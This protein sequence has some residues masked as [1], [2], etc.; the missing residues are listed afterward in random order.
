MEYIVVGPGTMPLKEIRA[1]VADIMESDPAAVFGAVVSGPI[2]TENT[3]KTVES[4]FKSSGFLTPSEAGNSLALYL[5]E[6]N[7]DESLDNMLPELASLCAV[8]EW[9]AEGMFAGADEWPIKLLVLTPQ[10]GTP[11]P[12]ELTDLIRKAIKSGIPAMA[13]N[14][15]MYELTESGSESEELQELSRDELKAMALKAGVTAEDWRSKDSIIEALGG[16]VAETSNEK[17]VEAPVSASPEILGVLVGHF[18]AM[19]ELYAE[20][21]DKLQ[22]L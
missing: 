20:T 22:N 3:I 10:Q 6:S 11:Y 1:V 5:D 13:F 18:K 4:V 7:H 17:P 21:A 8:Y 14:E 16:N 9:D 12:Q 2:T 19:S 15:Q